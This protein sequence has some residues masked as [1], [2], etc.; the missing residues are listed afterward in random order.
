[1]KMIWLL[2]V[3]LLLPIPVHAATDNSLQALNY[4]ACMNDA[5]EAWAPTHYHSATRQ[6][7][8]WMLFLAEKNQC[9]KERRAYLETF[10]PTTWDMIDKKSHDFF[11]QEVTKSLGIE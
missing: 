5:A 1:M 8:A 11:I 6:D 4:S 10:P 2:A 3:A 7:I 9:D